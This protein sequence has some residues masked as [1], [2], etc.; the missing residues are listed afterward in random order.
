[1]EARQNMPQNR[2]VAVVPLRSDDCAASLTIAG[3]SVLDSTVRAL[4]SVPEIGAIV[5]ALDGIAADDCLS[6]I[7]D[8][9]SLGILTSST[10]TGRWAAIA[11][12]LVVAGEAD[13][14][15]LHDP[16]RP[17]VPPIAIGQLL[18]QSGPDAAT[19]SAM[20]VNSSIKRV[21]DGRIVAT[22]PRE[23]LHAA[24]S[25]WVFGRQRLEDALHTAIDG[26]WTAEDE[27]ELVRRAG[28]P[29]RIAEGHLFNVPIASRAD[30]RFAEMAVGRRLVSLPGR[31]A[32]PA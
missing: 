24:Q 25:P 23:T 27:L 5:L 3:R 1:M 17:L 18:L 28:I 11:S 10:S 8:P 31:F 7:H 15:L 9:R 16:D 21:V 20:P 4:R 29:V 2:V 26:S 22:V 13:T 32:S 19:V 14:V 6:A 12:A 30:A